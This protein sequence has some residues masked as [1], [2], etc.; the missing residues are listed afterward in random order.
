M[1]P[2]S[3]LVATP[4]P[5]S[6]EPP[7]VNGRFATP[8]R[9]ERAEHPRGPIGRTSESVPAAFDLG[10]AAVRSRL[11]AVRNAWA[12]AIEDRD[13]P[14][15]LR[16]RDAPPSR[17][18]RE[19][20]SSRSAQDRATSIPCRRHRRF[21][22][23]H[24]SP[25]R[26]DGV[27]R[28]RHYSGPR[29]LLRLRERRV[30]RAADDRPRLGRDLRRPCRTHPRDAHLVV[31]SLRACWTTGPRGPTWAARQR[32]CARG[33]HR[34][35]RSVGGHVVH[36]RFAAREGG[37]ARRTAR[38]GLG[39]HSDLS[40]PRYPGPRHP[41]P[42]YTLADRPPGGTAPFGDTNAE[43]HYRPARPTA[44]HRSAT[45]TGCRAPGRTAWWPLRTSRPARE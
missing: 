45:D 17:R 25:R 23:L 18:Q 27:R 43:T 7:T 20:S 30:R 3:P 12:E 33:L 28:V 4:E 15:A 6:H 34:R 14:A 38:A 41:A 32:R 22:R 1:I 16:R 36:I 8:R 31:P 26:R 42:C 37:P 24:R 39:D 5:E 29:H 10:P 40:D 35:S 44:D 13:T 21:A 2:R 19:V 9:R 11:R